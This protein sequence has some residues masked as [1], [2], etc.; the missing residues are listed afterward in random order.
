[1]VLLLTGE[2]L[3][4]SLVYRSNATGS[5]LSS[6]AC[7]V[8]LPGYEAIITSILNSSGSLT[9]FF[10]FFLPS[11]LKS[12]LQTLEVIVFIEL[13]LSVLFSRIS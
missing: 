8:A 7:P 4:M 6:S 13:I 10:F 3:V 5:L 12:Y 2:N 11:T 9:F 1:M